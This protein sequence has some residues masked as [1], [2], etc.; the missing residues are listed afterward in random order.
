MIVSPTLAARPTRAPQAK[1][2]AFDAAAAEA[3]ELARERD[4]MD[5]LMMAFLKHE[6]AIMK[7]WIEMI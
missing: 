3:A 7:K 2:A 4:A 5:E 1:A 6:D